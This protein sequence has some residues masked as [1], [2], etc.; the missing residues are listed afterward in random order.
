K[1]DAVEEILIETA[2]RP[3]PRT[4]AADVGGE[5]GDSTGG[6]RIDDH[7]GAGIIDAAGALKKVRGTRGVGELGLA[8]SLAFAGASALARR[9]RGRSTGLGG[10]FAAALVLGSSGLFVLPWLAG[11]AFGS[12]VN[13]ASNGALGAVDALLA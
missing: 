10:G 12:V 2:R 5:L 7:Y 6:A 3:P 1:P 4:S 8:L 13:V 11:G 9:G